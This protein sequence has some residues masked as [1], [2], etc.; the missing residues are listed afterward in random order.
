VTSITGRQVCC[1][2]S[3][4]NPHASGQGRSA[5]VAKRW[6]TVAGFV[7]LIARAYQSASEETSA[8]YSPCCGQRRV[9]STRPASTTTLASTRALQVGQTERVA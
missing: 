3:G 1:W 7:V 4:H 6:G 2:C 8:V 5:R 9:S